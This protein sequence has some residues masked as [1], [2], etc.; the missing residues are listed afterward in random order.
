MAVAT[1]NIPV[2][3]TTDIQRSSA[4]SSVSESGS[5]KDYIIWSEIL[6]WGIEAGSVTKVSPSF[7]QPEGFDLRT[8]PASQQSLL[9]WGRSLIRTHRE[10]MEIDL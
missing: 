4:S 7:Y 1:T 3:K 2:W 6:G 8:T 10:R 5:N 9:S